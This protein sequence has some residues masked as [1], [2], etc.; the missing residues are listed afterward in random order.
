MVKTEPSDH[1]QEE[2]GEAKNNSNS[3]SKGKGKGKG[4]GNTEVGN[5]S[6]VRDGS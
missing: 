2:S 6:P 1:M 4:K 3:K 5:G